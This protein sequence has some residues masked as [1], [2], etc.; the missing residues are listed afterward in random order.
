M[1]RLFL[2]WMLVGALIVAPARSLWAQDEEEAIPAPGEET[3]EPAPEPVK[4]KPKPKPAEEPAAEPAPEPVKPKVQPKPAE[5]PAAEPALEP[6]KP[7]PKPKPKAKPVEAPVEETEAAEPAPKPKPKAAPRKAEAPAQSASEA[8]RAQVKYL[9]E[10]FKDA[11]EETLPSILEQIEVHLQQYRDVEGADQAL[12]LKADVHEKLGDYSSA[13]MDHL[14]LLYEYPQTKLAFN[15]KKKLMEIADRR[16]RKQ[17]QPIADMMKAVD[18]K[19]D[20]ADR[21]AALLRAAVALQERELTVPLVAELNNFLRRY[22]EH[23]AA[24]EMTF[25]MGKVHSV[26]ANYKAA[27]LFFEK[28]LALSNDG[29]L[30][31]RAQAAIGDIYAVSLRDYNKAIEAYQATTDRFADFPEAGEAYVK[32]A[33]IQ[34]ENLKQP[35]LAVELLE[36]I[37]TLYPKSDAAYQSLMEQSRIYSYKLK[38]YNRAVDALKKVADDFPAEKAVEALKQAAELARSYLKD[39]SMQA[40]FLERIGT[41]FSEHKDAPQA[42][43]DAG[44]MYERQLSNNA[45]ALK[46]YQTLVS[47]FAANPLAKK[48]S[49]RVDY[50]NR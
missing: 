18:P 29:G 40:E 41:D 25:L 19:L 37:T 36:K 24:G 35:N 22:P 50:L 23:P 17:K 2:P 21:F 8:A 12:Y 47:K 31:A 3:A 30:G 28:I 15:A 27:V 14:R 6:V 11:T 46:V 5:E 43:W 26:N 4:P 1:G 44:Q 42:L 32:W 34:D 16:F 13:A 20:R 10:A 7:K 9:Q 49:K 38:D 33:K 48:A 45:A 39:Q